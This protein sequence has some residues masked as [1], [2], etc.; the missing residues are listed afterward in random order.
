METIDDEVV[1]TYTDGEKVNLGKLANSQG[2]EGPKGEKGD[3]GE[4]GEA[5]TNGAN[6]KDGRGV[7]GA[8]IDGGNLIL[9]YTDGTAENLG[10]V[11]GATTV[12]VEG[13][14]GGSSTSS[15]A[16]WLWA[17]LLLIPV[18]IAAL[19]STP[20]AQPYLQQAREMLNI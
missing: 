19:L 12:K 1:V 8:K 10:R 20:M 13:E 16:S 5:G 2:P 7:A 3:Q 9:T 6:G 4:K 18:G 15:N 14:A 17:L 11:E